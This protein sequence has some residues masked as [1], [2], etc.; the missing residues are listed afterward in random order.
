MPDESCIIPEC[1][2]DTLLISLLG[3]KKPTHKFG[4]GGVAKVMKSDF[5]NKTAIGVIDDDNKQPTYFKSFQTEQRT[6]N[7]I[8]K[9]APEKKHFLVVI[10][11][12]FER[13]IFNIAEELDVEPEKYGFKTEKQFRNASK[14]VN[15]H[16]NQN[17]KQFLN[18]LIQ[19]KNSP[20]QNMQHWIH[21]K[22]NP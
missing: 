8:F 17:V 13:C 11:P 12:A 10:T 19:K 14:D 15:V 18:T 2:A 21:E 20:L 7:F 3:F 22:L 9:Y 6:R 5:K 1:Y 16:K 4:I